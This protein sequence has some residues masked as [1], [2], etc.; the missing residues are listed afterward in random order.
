MPPYWTRR[1]RFRN[2]RRKRRFRFL[3]WRTRQTIRR[4]YRTRKRY[5]RPYKVKRRRYN[6]KKTKLILKQFQ[7]STINKCKIIGYKCLFQGSPLRTS[8]NYIQYVYST[9]PPFWPGGG[10]WSLLVFSLESLYEDFLHIQNLWTKSNAGLPLV[11]FLGSKFK[12]YQ[13]ADTDYVVSYDRCWP[14]VDTEHTHADSCPIRMLQRRHKVIIPSRKSQ[15]RKKPYK[16]VFIKPPSQMQTKWYFQR[17]ICKIP[18]LMLTA[19]SVDLRYPFCSPQAKSNNITIRFLS[20]FLFQN[21]NFAHYPTTTGYWPKRTDSGEK[22]YLYASHNALPNDINTDFVKTLIPLCNTT[23]YQPGKQL[24]SAGYENKPENW[25]NPFYHDYINDTNSEQTMYLFLSK[26]TPINMLEYIKANGAKPTLTTVTG[27]TIYDT[28][29][30]PEKDTGEKNK[31]YL[32]SNGSKETIEPPTNTNYIFEGFP[33]FI[34]L[35]SWTDFIK[36]L[37]DTPDIDKYQFLVIETDQFETKL[38]KYIPIDTD[39][40][41]GYDPYTPEDIKNNPQVPHTPNIYNKNSWYPKLLFQQQMIE[42]ICSAG[43]AYPRPASNNYLQAYCKYCFY[44]K[45]GGCP[46]TL[47]KAYDPCLQSKWTTTDNIGTR[48]EITNPFTPPETQLYSFDWEKDYVNQKAIERIQYYTE[49]DEP[50]ISISGNKNNPSTFK[51]AQEKNSAEKEEEALQQQL[52]KLR[53]KRMLLEL[54]LQ[55]LRVELK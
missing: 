48:L 54:H 31:I 11:R 50:N 5:R 35:W 25:G 21:P 2:Y 19:T 43:P 10:G 49:I 32:V 39:F 22:L 45:W 38:P 27:P 24:S 16:K 33:L 17:D 4:R 7:P 41:E 3:P 34:L 42:R 9:V 51:K 36:K 37:K 52:L 6:R 18:L 40:T 23:T 47:Q 30:N 46:K 55:R 20:P 26:T 8:K 13:S 29:Y 53:H 1:Y 12:F 44:F 15:S 14:M 28:R